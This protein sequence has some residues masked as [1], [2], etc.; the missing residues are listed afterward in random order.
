MREGRDLDLRRGIMALGCLP[1]HGMAL[2]RLPLHGGAQHA[3]ANASYN[4]QR[5]PYDLGRP[6][7]LGTA[8]PPAA[9]LGTHRADGL[10]TGRGYSEYWLGKSPRTSRVARVKAPDEGGRLETSDTGGRSE[11][12]ARDP[13]GFAL[14]GYRAVPLAVDGVD[15]SAERNMRDGG[16]ADGGDRRHRCAQPSLPLGQPSLRVSPFQHLSHLVAAL[17]LSRRTPT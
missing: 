11:G 15:V 8:R 9:R 13:T 5:T 12:T 10:E 2:G 4:I 3:T 6:R 14:C 16:V 1:L 7:P 17:P